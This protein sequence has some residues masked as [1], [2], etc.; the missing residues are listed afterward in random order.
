MATAT[1]PPNR[2]RQYREA[3][4]WSQAELARRAGISRAAVSAVEIGRVDP[5]VG[6]A[7][8]LGSALGCTVEALFCPGPGMLTGPEWAWPPAESTCRY[9]QAR[10]GPR[11]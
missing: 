1:D 4:G 6:A 5:S 10:V 2:V 9:W 3:R 7:L 8:A 11:N